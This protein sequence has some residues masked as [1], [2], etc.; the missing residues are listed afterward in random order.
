M[1]FTGLCNAQ[2]KQNT[3]HHEVQKRLQEVSLEQNVLAQYR[4]RSTH[5]IR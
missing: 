4:I 2:V 1:H 3:Q 5:L